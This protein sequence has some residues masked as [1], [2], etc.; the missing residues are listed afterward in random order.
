MPIIAALVNVQTNLVM[1]KIVA[2][3]PT[4]PAPAD[5]ILVP[6]DFV[7]PPMD[8]R[9]AALIERRR[10]QDPTYTVNLNK[11]LR[12]VHI[13]QTLWTPEL[14][15]HERSDPATD[16]QPPPIPPGLP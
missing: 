15:F 8:E 3:A 13:G 12:T 5:T 6:I 1:A 11:V 10:Q 4:D 16:V 14:G 7:D 2:S 9:L